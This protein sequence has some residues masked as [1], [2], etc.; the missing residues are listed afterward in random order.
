MSWVVVIA[1]LASCNRL[2]DDTKIL[3]LVLVIQSCIIL[4]F[5]FAVLA[6]GHRFGTTPECNQNTR[7]VIFRPFSALKAG[8]IFGGIF[9]GLAFIGYTAMT[10]RDCW[11]QIRDKR[12]GKEPPTRKGDE[13]SSLPQR[14]PPVTTTFIPSRREP[15]TPTKAR[16]QTPQKQVRQL[17]FHVLYSIFIYPCMLANT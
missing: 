5:A 4:A 13:A 12:K 6:T 15:R 10:A 8:R 7:V 2:S 3:Q 1:S 16:N 17:C 11:T 9:F 14:Q